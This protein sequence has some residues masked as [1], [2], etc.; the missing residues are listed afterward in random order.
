M[1]HK[2]VRDN[3]NWDKPE[4]YENLGINFFQVGQPNKTIAFTGP[5]EQLEFTQALAMAE[6]IDWRYRKEQISYTFNTEG[7]RNDFDFDTVDWHKSVGV[8]GC[9]HIFGKGVNQRHTVP[10]YIGKELEMQTVNLGCEG[11]SIR[12]VF[13]NVIHLIEKYN[14]KAIAI[15][16]PRIN[17]VSLSY[18]W[19]TIEN[20]WSNL[21]M[22]GTEKEV[23]LF[24]PKEPDQYG[25]ISN[26]EVQLRFR[27][28]WPRLD[29][30]HFIENQDMVYQLNLYRQTLKL[31]AHAKNID[32]YDFALDKIVGK[33]MNQLDQVKAPYPEFMKANFNYR[34]D[35]DKQNPGWINMPKE[36]RQWW[37]DNVCAR[38]IVSIKDGPAGAHFGPVLN[39][40]IA[41]LIIENK[42]V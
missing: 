30:S 21:D 36:H 38:D 26:E 5:Q 42:L 23:S 15:L 19:D 18:K 39:K 31:L 20:G 1:I 33:K 29:E 24:R 17:R 14:P 25:L 13:N 4:E 7:F 8:I 28:L 34:G 11:A 10:S 3:I 35:F 6:L 27:D 41:K 12:T 37:V 9:S 40:A 32:L 16:W 2:K 22:T